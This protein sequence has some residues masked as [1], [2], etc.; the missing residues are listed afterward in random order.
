MSNPK[1]LFVLGSQRGGTTIFGQLLGEIDGFVF[2]GAVRRLWLIGTRQTCSCGLPNESC[3]L[4]S[5]VL[6]AVTP[7]GQDAGEVGVWQR[8]HL[9]NRHSW[10][11]ALRLAR[12]QKLGRDRS[13]ELAG[14]AQVSERLYRQVAELTGAR[15]VV[16]TSKHPNDAVLLSQMSGLDVYFV[17]IV[18]DPRGSAHSVQL[19]HRKRQANGKRASTISSMVDGG[20][21]AY[22]TV[23]WITRHGTTE[24]LRRMAPPER[25]L[26][27]RYED[28]VERPREVLQHVA[29]F[30]GEA[31]AAPPRFSDGVVELSETH[32]PSCA[33]RLSAAAIPIRHDDRWLSS[34]STR[35]RFI[36]VALAWPLMRRYGYPL[37]RPR[38]T[39]A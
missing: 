23:H 17:Q 16:D 15:V 22:A 18:R 8:H 32:S 12:H 24:A 33:K 20:H 39:D 10:V 31:D 27:V 35:D 13:P 38:L 3:P 28:L 14:Y 9:S 25:S 21:T 2:A 26:L 36:T 11:G 5:A 1:V 19:R 34:L 7:D 29:A 37:R 6:P 30:M 4:W